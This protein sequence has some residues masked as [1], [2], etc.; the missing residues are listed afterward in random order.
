ML[1]KAVAVF[2][3]LAFVVFSAS[4]TVYKVKQERIETVAKKGGK[5]RSLAFQTKARDYFEFRQDRPATISGGALVGEYLKTVEFKQEDIARQ[6]PAAAGGAGEILTKDGE[7]YTVRT[8][9]PAGDRLVCQ[10]YLPVSIPLSEIQSAW[11]KSVNTGAT[12]LQTAAFVALF[13][14]VIALYVM[15]PDLSDETDIFAMD[16]DA[17]EPPPV[18]LN[19]WENYFVDAE[20]HGPTAGQGFTMTEWTAAESV[21]P[22]DGKTKI[23]L[24]NELDEP[25]A[26][27]ELRI[28]VVDHP[29]GMKVVPDLSGAMHTVPAA[30][31]PR[32]ARDR[33]GRDIL[34]LVSA[35]DGRSWM[36]S[37]EEKNPRKKED[38]RD[39]LIFEFPKPPGAKKVKLLV[40]ATN[41]AW[42]SNFASSFIGIPGTG[43]FERPPKADMPALAGGRARDWFREDEFYRLRV[44]VETKNGWQTRQMI[45]GGGPFVP[46]D[47][48][49]VL[50]IKDVPGSTLKV[51]LMPPAGFWMIDRIAVDYSKD[52][53]SAPVEFMAEEAVAPD[54]AAG[55]V[56]AALAREDGRCLM[57]PSRGDAAE[58]TFTAPPLPAGKERSIILKTACRYEIRP[59]LISGD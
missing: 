5:D 39:E 52:S 22:V 48:I 16:V 50:N 34:P 3:L 20:L 13:V 12:I 11:V 27:D 25:K 2:T 55:D 30:A 19:F 42:A 28:I 1:R 10:A 49:Y 17:P 9:H 7:R 31:A 41:T 54:L 46:R 26:T 51:K 38:L 33:H 23:L 32:R 15:S 58:I 53:A 24:K 6:T 56:L 18:Y 4:C 59:G 43:S 29:P 44:W 36:T 40:N 21:T 37:D 47:M 35:K 14:V 8:A 57:L 45:Y